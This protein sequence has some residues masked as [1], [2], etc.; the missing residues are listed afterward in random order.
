MSRG[1]TR[2]WLALLIALALGYAVLAHWLTT[3]Q[4]R[5]ALGGLGPY[6]PWF[7]FLQH[8]AMFIALA[9]WFGASLRAGREALVTRFALLVEGA[10]SPAGLAY[11]RGATLA[12]AVFSAAVAAASAL[13]YFLA[14]LALWSLFANLLTLPLVG[15]MFVAEFLVRI[16]VCP[17]LSHGGLLRG[18]T[19]SVRAY[20]ESGARP[21]TGPR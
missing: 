18:V 10:L 19:R 20:W 14:P 8:I 5:T 1:R 13:L 16:R 15:A 11:T 17:E 9:V 3:E 12:W 4:G 6:V 7:Y 2:G 21:T